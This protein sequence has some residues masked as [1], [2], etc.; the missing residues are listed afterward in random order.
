MWHMFMKKAL[1][2]LIMTAILLAVA[3]KNASAD[4]G[5]QPIYGGGETCPP[6]SIAVEK[7]VLNPQTNNYV[8]NL[9]VNDP[10]YQ[11]QNLVFF[12]IKVANTSSQSIKSVGVKDT[13]PDVL[14]FVSLSSADGKGD[15][16][17]T[18]TGNDVS[19]T[20]NNLNGND[21]RLFAL[22]ARAQ[23]STQLPSDQPVVCKTNQVNATT[24]ANQSA[25]A[26]SE[27]CIEHQVPTTETVLSPTPT[28]VQTKGGL[29]VFPPTTVKSNPPTG[30]EL[31]TL[32][33][34]IPMGGI[35]VWLRKKTGK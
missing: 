29:P 5:C 31:S 24:D 32:L 35:G 21:N 22:V 7:T 18:N 26:S 3:S 27:F 30:P 17:V 9:G 15:V 8:D 12:H 14:S 34:L 4:S 19:F 28:Q 20:I 6:T 16:S 13:L 23:A 11:A 33:G 25:S 10:K 1:V 2:I